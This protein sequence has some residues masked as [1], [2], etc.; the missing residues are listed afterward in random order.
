MLSAIKEF[1]T[2]LMAV[3]WIRKSY[4]INT[5]NLSEGIGVSAF[6][7]HIF[8]F[9]LPGAFWF[10]HS[11]TW[12]GRRDYYRQKKT[13]QITSP[14]LRRNIHRLEKALIMTPRRPIFASKYIQETVDFFSTAVSQGGLFPASIE[15]GEIQWAQDVLTTYFES[16]SL[17]NGKIESARKKFYSLPLDRVAGSN[18]PGAKPVR[19]IPSFEALLALS[20]QRRSS[21][22]FQQRPVPRGLVDQALLVARQSPSACNRLPY[23]FII[24]DNPESVKRLASIPFGSAGFRHNIPTLVV[25]VGHLSHFFSARDRH[26]VYI[27]SALAAMS[28]SL[29]LETLELS[30]T[31]INWPEIAPL[32]YKIKQELGLLASDR[33]VLMMAVGF[34]DPRAHVPFSSKKE[35]DL[36]RVYRDEP[37]FPPVGKL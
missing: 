4:E 33:V 37:P 27:D 36:L 11:A 18:S 8:Y 14:G 2:S 7:I 35:L 25:V 30:S 1:L 3:G 26:T 34:P 31:I 6:L 19:S 13:P 24:F 28:F 16:I 22:W 10:E 17:P 32:D 21:R 20:E 12:R 5:R 23:S 15:R 29:A 9:L